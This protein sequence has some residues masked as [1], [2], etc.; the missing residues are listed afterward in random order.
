MLLEE[1]RSSSSYSSSSKL[2]YLP[3]VPTHQTAKAL[4]SDG[5]DQGM[6]SVLKGAGATPKYACPW[7]ASIHTSRLAAFVRPPMHLGRSIVDIW[8]ALLATR[9]RKSQEGRFELGNGPEV[10]RFCCFMHFYVPSQRNFV[11]LNQFIV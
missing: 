10:S 1:T 3:C 2:S 4:W 5:K 6:S 9:A 8:N 11:L 7:Y